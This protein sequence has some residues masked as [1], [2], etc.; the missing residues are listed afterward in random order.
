MD[1]V[2]AA[3]LISG[4]INALQGKRGSDL[5]KSTISDAALA[6]ATGGASE[7]TEGI[8]TIEGI[9]DLGQVG[10]NQYTNTG[11]AQQLGNTALQGEQ[12]ATRDALNAGDYM[13]YADSVQ[14]TAAPT[15]NFFEKGLSGLEKG[16]SAIEKPFR[17]P[18]TGQISKFRVGLGAGALG[19]GLYAAG[20]FKPTPPPE[21]KY[22]GYNR[23]YA[24]DPGMFQPFSGKYGPD[25]SKYPSGAPYSG[26]A[27]GGIASPDDSMMQYAAEQSTPVNNLYA[28]AKER[29][30]LTKSPRQIMAEASQNTSGQ[31]DLAEAMVT[32][33]PVASIETMS[34]TLPEAIKRKYIMEYQTDPKGTALKFAQE[35][36]DSDRLSL[37]DIDKATK[38]LDAMSK[39]VKMPT[40]D[41]KGILGLLGENEVNVPKAPDSPAYVQKLME[42]IQAKAVNEPNKAFADGDLVDV[43]PSKLIRN[44]NDEMNY[45]RTSGKMVVDE[46]GKGKGNKDTM[47]AQLADGEFVTKSESVLGAGK[48]MGGKS[49]EEQR[50][51]GA[52]FF[53]KQMAEL[54]K[55]A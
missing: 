24:A 4:G 33:V 37:S 25:T 42:L 19:A 8:S 13:Q 30:G 34:G 20:A 23:F 17:D 49:K 11:I 7:G 52:Q 36:S 12:F 26:L 53:Y 54:E 39:D 44:E 50:K 40:N 28:M 9:D 32:G 3:L 55:F 1:P 15:Q 41:L 43:L 48:L 45:K 16:M 21:P 38:L 51:L 10:I 47:L 22:P 27:Q 6:Y 2:T 46:T 29:F 18:V 14:T 35:M 31:L 5:L